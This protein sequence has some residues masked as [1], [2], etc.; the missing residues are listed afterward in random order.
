VRDLEHQARL[1]LFIDGDP[2]RAARLLNEYVHR[3]QPARLPPEQRP[4]LEL[5]TLFARSGEVD[6]ARGWLR[7]WETEVAT[8]NARKDPPAAW[9]NAMAT[10]ALTERRF[11]DALAARQRIE[12]AS[13]PCPTCN[14]FYIG[15]I[16]DRGGRADSAVVYYE[17][18]LNA[19]DW[20]RLDADQELLWL[21]RRRLGE[22]Y[23][24][25]G[26][27]ARALAYYGDLLEQW[28][29]GDDVVKP[30]IRDIRGRVV[31]LA[32]ER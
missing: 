4:Y 15:E 17:R 8:E 30:I 14:L 23:E 28:T 19:K 10:V 6:H 25:R 21:A 12:E 5:A 1:A 29:D 24:R 13:G 7:R 26:D 32:A 18:W 31:R 3:A 22:L 9:H 20:Y 2:E 16:H 11:D 27:R